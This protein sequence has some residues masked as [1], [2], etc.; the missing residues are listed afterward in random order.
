MSLIGKQRSGLARLLTITTSAVL[1]FLPSEVEAQTAPWTDVGV[2]GGMGATT[3]WFSVADWNDVLDPDI[4]LGIGINPIFGAQA[5]YWPDPLF[6]VRGHLGYLPSPV[7]HTDEI[8]GFGV[9][10][11]DAAGAY[12][13]NNYFFDLSGVVRPFSSR[14]GGLGASFY[15]WLG[16][17]LMFTNAADNPS[18]DGDRYGCRPS[19]IPLGACLPDESRYATVGQLA[20]G[21][22]LDLIQF[23]E[24][25]GIFGELGA[26]GYDSPVHLDPARGEDR[27]A[28]TFRGV[29]G[30]KL[31][32]WRPEPPPVPVRT[33][34]APPPAPAPPV[35]RQIQICVVDAGSLR[36]VEAVFRPATGDTLVGGRPFAVVHP[37]VAPAYATGTAWFIEQDSLAFEGGTWVKFGVTREIGPEVL[38][39][40]GEVAG[41]PLFAEAGREAP[42]EV[43]YVP[44]RPG[45]EF[46]PYQPRIAIR[47]RA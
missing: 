28:W 2:Y 4:D 37:T 3:P 39:R 17:G 41:T 40:I 6:G 34:A 47:P 22:G 38:Q 25:F 9:F 26:H 10:P 7:P 11:S 31:R 42:F 44:V 45:C 16:G 20:T 5:T 23:N 1:C 32:L 27:F 24:F 29:A 12:P 18:I 8:S 15:L 35:E 33:V 36:N 13:L 46:Q 14:A 19:F 43:L 21:A 30:V